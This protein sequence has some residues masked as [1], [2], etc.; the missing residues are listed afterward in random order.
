[1]PVP[2]VGRHE[3]PSAP[4]R[5]DPVPPFDRREAAPPGDP[6]GSGA[7]FDPRDPTP[8]AD[9]PPATP[10]ADRREP[11][12]AGREQPSPPEADEAEPVSAGS[13]RRTAERG[14]S[15]RRRGRTIIV[16]LAVL[17]LGG[18]AAGGA[19]TFFT[20]FATP[21]FEGTGVGDVVVQVEDG[22]STTRIAGELAENGVVASAA[23]F[24]NAAEDDERIRGVQPG[25]YQLRRQMSGASAV[26]LMLDPASRVGQLEI[27][28]GVQLDD[29]SAPDGSVAPG[30]L[31]L[32]S[33]ATCVRRDGEEQCVSV[34]E[35]RAAMSETDPATL[36]VPEWAL[37][38]VAEAEP[39]RRLEGLLLPGRYDVHPGS[40]AA[41]VLKELLATS[42]ARLE[43]TG[44]VSGARSI[45]SSPYEVL[46]IASLVEKEAITP[47]M[48]QVAR[49][50]YNRLGAGRRLELDSMVNYPLDLQALRTTAED[51]TRPGPYNS[52][53]VTG[54]PPT[55]IAAAG[56]EAIAAALE[57]A[58][59]PWMYF[60]RCQA[61]G[62]SCFAETYEEHD[63]NVR[64]ARANG[65][66]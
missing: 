36:G 61:D 41:D 55:P 32:I 28:G 3:P 54:L 37:E 7:A 60:V 64:E 43:A 18:V 62:T 46:T 17:L 33:R 44:L 12:P 9:R 38:D 52:Y 56:R 4:A 39:R 59:G 53:V 16:L 63:A 30:V 14:T 48:P 6:R 49:V 45:G 65:A 57:P 35:L 21:D 22:D 42:A 15:R 34:D 29:T 8:P 23:A 51:R 66:F 25:Y 11:A 13:S 5:R 20:W 24:T 31:S 58:A 1:M 47:D 40:T 26:A 50:I 2:V 19:Y 10:P 27:R